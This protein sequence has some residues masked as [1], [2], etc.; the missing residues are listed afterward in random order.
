MNAPIDVFQ[1]QRVLFYAVNLALTR[2]VW[3]EP[4]WPR[5]NG[6]LNVSIVYIVTLQH[7]VKWLFHFVKYKKYHLS[8]TKALAINKPV[9]IEFGDIKHYDRYRTRWM[10]LCVISYLGQWMSQIQIKLSAIFAFGVHAKNI[11]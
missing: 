3:I 2:P 8:H 7:V 4:H 1:N 5:G 6:S 9:E 11:L 10:P